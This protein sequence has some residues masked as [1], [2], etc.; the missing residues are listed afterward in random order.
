MALLAPTN[1]MVRQN[2]AAPT[3]IRTMMAS[4]SA[5]TLP[6]INVGSF[7]KVLNPR[8]IAEHTGITLG[9][10]A[11]TIGVN[12]PAVVIPPAY[13]PAY[14]GMGG[15]GGGGGG[16][17]SSSSSQEEEEVYDPQDDPTFANNN[18]LSVNQLYTKAVNYG[19]FNGTFREF[20]TVYNQT[21]EY[22]V[23][24][25]DQ[26]EQAMLESNDNGPMV[27][28]PDQ[29]PTV[30]QAPANYTP[31]ST[32]DTANPSSTN[33]TKTGAQ[34]F[35]KNIADGISTNFFGTLGGLL[36]LGLDSASKVIDIKAKQKALNSQ[37]SNSSNSPA[38]TTNKRYPST[39]PTPT[40]PSATGMSPAILYGGIGIAVVLIIVGV[41]MSKKSGAVAVGGAA[42]VA[43]PAPSK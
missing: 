3:G 26:Y 19:L 24:N 10:S 17:D 9:N 25:L 22:I 29:T 31:T 32:T 18:G 33:T 5:S 6:N 23:G 40:I 15:G 14:D 28:A 36:N 7:R 39:T 34:Q 8:L 43:S 42:P 38:D 37:D 2:L 41:V 16:G 13:I 12:T 4:S 1:R 21:P 30:E 27:Y 11:S 20:A 35:G